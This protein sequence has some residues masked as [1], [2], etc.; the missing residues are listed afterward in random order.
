MRTG[1]ING[2]IFTSD[3]NNLYA[4]FMVIE[5]GKI[6][7]IGSQDVD[8]ASS[9]GLDVEKLMASCDDV[10]DL[11]EKC[12][13]P[14][15]VDAHMHPLMLSEYNR[16]ISCLPPKVNSISDMATEISKVAQDLKN[17]G[18]DGSDTP[19]WI[20]GWGY[21][22][23]KLAENR[24]PN[25]YDL[26]KG[27][28]DFPVTISRT[29]GHIRCV[30]SKALELAG[31][32]KDTKDPQGGQIDRDENGEPTGVLREN[33]RD[34]VSNLIPSYSFEE[35]VDALLE[36]EQLLLSQGI[37]AVTDMGYLSNEDPYEVYDAAVK[38][39][40]K[41]NV[42]IYYFWDYFHGTSQDIFSKERQ[43]LNNQIRSCGVKLIGDGSLSGQ[44]AWMHKPYKDTDN[45]G[46]PVY[47]DEL[48]EDAL[49]YCKKY[50]CQLA[51]HAM[52][53]RAI[54]RII[55][56]AIL[57]SNWMENDIPYVR[58]EH[59][60]EPTVDAMKK[61]AANGI[62]FVTQPIFLYCE[63]ESYLKNLGPSRTKEAYPIKDI[64][65]NNVN[66]AFST[67][68]P[69]TSWAVPSDPFS[70]LKAAVTRVAYDG[71]DIGKENA[72]DVETAIILYTK[73]AAQVS[74]FTQSGQ[75]KPGYDADFIIL[76]DDIFTI[77]P[78]K[79]DSITVEKTFIKGDCVYTK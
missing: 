24:S 51:V 5:N 15:F 50:H 42:G 61:A 54:D 17:Q 2:K 38:R 43:N 65:E 4:D 49:S 66:L 76:S 30:N 18:L 28:S 73:N 59:L 46:L 58:L 36:L 53:G 10:I 39:G 35:R 33:A 74:G 69:A 9:K 22:E 55:D 57:E 34:L 63:I 21:D 6:I 40:F 64:L 62:A 47:S 67:D 71:T 27:T 44:T 32:T 14:A 20:Q 7:D 23:G 52:G 79:I 11:K 77:D 3:V 25:R 8:A 70:N 48:Y 26:D 78:N 72:V 45:Y 12:L 13:I 19:V 29:C 56:S 1:Y 68:A 16:Q 37:A 60:T 31:I 41:Q 75:L